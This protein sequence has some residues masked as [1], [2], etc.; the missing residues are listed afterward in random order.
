MDGKTTLRCTLGL[1]LC[2]VCM[3]FATMPASAARTKL[4][5]LRGSQLVI[6]A[7]RLDSI[8]IV[9]TQG[10]DFSATSAGVHAG[11]QGAATAP[12]YTAGAG[13]AGTVIGL[14]ISTS[15]EN[16]SVRKAANKPI[17]PLRVAYATHHE[18]LGFEDSLE[19]AWTQHAPEQQRCTA[20]AG[21]DPKKRARCET[22]L[23]L[24]PLLTLLPKARVLCVSI[25]AKLHDGSKRPQDTRDRPLYSTRLTFLSEPAAVAQIDELNEHWRKDDFQAIKREWSAALQTLMPL[26]VAE[27]ERREKAVQG[28][29]QAI[30]YVNAG[31]LFYERGTILSQDEHRVV[32]RALDGSLSSVHVDRFLS[33]DEYYQWLRAPP[34]SGGTPVDGASPTAAN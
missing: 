9:P 28:D 21:T 34:V 10:P 4:E 24:R 18:F 16:S 31:G 6:D 20:D 19:Q 8:D 5:T 29:A 17:D 32:Y 2:G 30:R 33:I 23:M 14:L 15:M 3:T 27:L 22:R 7:S 11:V 26:L 1:L 12:G 25:E 13:V